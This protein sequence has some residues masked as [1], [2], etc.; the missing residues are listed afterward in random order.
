MLSREPSDVVVQ[1]YNAILTLKRL[2][3]NADCVVALDNTALNRI[4]VNQLKLECPNFSQ[5]NY[6][7]MCEFTGYSIQVATAMAASTATLR[8]PG[9]V[10][11]NLIS[12]IA[13]LV[14]TPRCHFVT[15]SL[16]PLEVENA[17][18]TAHLEI[19][20]TT[21]FDVM[22][23]LLQPRNFMVTFPPKGGLYVALLNIIRGQPEP[24]QV[25]VALEK[26]KSKGLAQFICWGPAS[27]QVSIA[28]Q[29][30]YTQTKNK[31]SGLLLANHTSVASVTSNFCRQSRE[32]SSSLI[33]PNNTTHL[34]GDKPSWTTT[35]E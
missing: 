29:S 3:L 34:S 19:R 10:N 15:T 14:P 30:S 13:P 18:S 35:G 11:N 24:S 26:V 31:L 4:A 9:F 1:P 20:K 21:V 2:T 8:F 16:T 22:R 5:T 25:R 6:L 28:S 33:A 32:N 23:R 12:T 7:V 27:I 17:S